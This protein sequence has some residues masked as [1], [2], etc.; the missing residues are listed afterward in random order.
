[1]KTITE[2]DTDKHKLR[3]L[4]RAYDNLKINPEVLSSEVDASS[5][6]KTIYA[7]LFDSFPTEIFHSS[8]GLPISALVYLSEFTIV[9]LCPVVSKYFVNY[10]GVT[11]IQLAVDRLSEE[12]AII[13]TIW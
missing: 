9:P 1:M 5:I 4:Q 12:Y 11:P 6:I 2:R 3:E 7:D 13:F 10:Y 8:F